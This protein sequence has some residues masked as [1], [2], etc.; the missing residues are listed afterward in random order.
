VTHVVRLAA[1]ARVATNTAEVASATTDPALAD[2]ESTAQIAVVVPPPVLGRTENA[3]PVSGTVLVQVPG[4]NR[5]VPLTA[6]T[7]LPVG[8]TIDT[9]RGRVR[10]QAARSGGGTDTAVFY[11]GIFRFFQTRAA[12][13]VTELRLS[14]GNFKTC[15]VGQRQPSAVG[16]TPK[17]PVRRLW[18][19]GKGR[20]R[21]RGRFGSA[22]VRGTRWL[23]VDRCD[24]TLIQV[25]VGRVTVRDFTRRRTV[26]V[27]A[28]RSYLA[29]ARRP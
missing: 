12:G 27:V 23:T 8:T 14:G 22:A 9:R 11:S 28:G 18:G 26:I 4:S 7:P 13:S 25:S 2:N 19:D 21:T 6:N 10:L 24:G 29:P 1:A 16:G 20:F 15:P 17:R 3:A 5:F